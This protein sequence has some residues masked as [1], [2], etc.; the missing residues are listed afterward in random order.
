MDRSWYRRMMK[1]IPAEDNRMD[2]DDLPT[3]A[4]R[5]SE[6]QFDE[7]RDLEHSDSSDILGY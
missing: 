5:G 6:L 7:I 4:K 3:L 1:N 2:Y